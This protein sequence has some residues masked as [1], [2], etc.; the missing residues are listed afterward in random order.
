MVKEDGW[1]KYS[2]GDF[3]SVYQ[4]VAIRDS[5]KGKPTFITA[6]KKSDQKKVH[7]KRVVIDNEFTD[8][9]LYSDTTSV[10]YQTEDYNVIDHFVIHYK[11]D[12]TN[13]VE[14]DYPLLEKLINYLTSDTQSL[15]EING[16]TDINGSILYN[17]ELSRQR[18]N[19]VWNELLYKYINSNRFTKNAY[20]ESRLVVKCGTNN[21]ACSDAVH[22][23]N[24]RVEVVIYKPR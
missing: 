6:Y 15:V 14:E 13:I 23:K 24:R 19:D 12:Q 7:M 9:D 17:M 22:S 1:Y 2:L 8:P 10:L 11:Y 20:G 16:H 3:N 4:A 5:L 18:A 21:V